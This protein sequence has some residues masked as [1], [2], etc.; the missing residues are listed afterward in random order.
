MV[1]IN[2]S[3]LHTGSF[4][5]VKF[6]KKNFKIQKKIIKRKNFQC[7]QTSLNH[8]KVTASTDCCII[9]YGIFG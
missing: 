5:K 8:V 7:C 2:I 9:T 1:R 3:F 4:E 6:N